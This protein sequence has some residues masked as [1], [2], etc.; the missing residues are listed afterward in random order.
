MGKLVNIK[1]KGKKTEKVFAESSDKRVKF[2]PNFPDNLMESSRD[3]Y[4]EL[5]LIANMVAEGG[6]YSAIVSGPAG[7]GKTTVVTYQLE[8][9]GWTEGSEFVVVKGFMTAAKL[10]ET[11]EDHNGKLLIFDDCDSILRDSVAKSLLMSALDDKP[12]RMVT[13]GTKSKEGLEALEFTGR[14]I[15][16]TNLKR[17]KR[18]AEALSSR[19]LVVELDL[20]SIE[21]CDYLEKIIVHV[22]YGKTTK[23]DRMRVL[24][25]L[26]YQVQRSN[27]RLDFRY[28]KS[29]LD[30]YSMRPDRVESKIERD[31]PERADTAVLPPSTL[32]AEGESK[33]GLI[34]YRVIVC[35]VHR[36]WKAAFEEAKTSGIVKPEKCFKPT[37]AEERQRVE[38]LWMDWPKDNQPRSY[39]YELHKCAENR[40]IKERNNML[41]VRGA[42]A[43]VFFGWKAK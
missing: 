5:L 40:E 17:L 7:L 1:N 2:P 36:D 33:G 38:R 26:K 25:Y 16:I 11:M 42:R 29:L 13:Y 19:S 10:F 24:N 35:G 30:Y 32:V 22:P 8:R 9:L 12:K 41:G 4:D 27:A 20:S 14:I 28:Y 21:I 15:F 43:Y 31:F 34:T 6:R 3:K 23:S 18:D 39:A 37:N